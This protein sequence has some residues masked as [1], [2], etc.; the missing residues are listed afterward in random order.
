LREFLKI[1]NESNSL[2]KFV[3][4]FFVWYQSGFDQ[5]EG[6]KYGILK[7]TAET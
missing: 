6:V 4:I 3:R 5:L 1:K 7:N 2:Y